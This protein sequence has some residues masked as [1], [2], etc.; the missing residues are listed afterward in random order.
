MSAYN[1]ELTVATLVEL[2]DAVTTSPYVGDGERSMLAELCGRIDHVSTTVFAVLYRKSYAT[3]RPPPSV[4]DVRPSDDA[5]TVVDARLPVEATRKTMALPVL[6]AT[7]QLDSNVPVVTGAT[8]GAIELVSATDVS[9]YDTGLLL[10]DGKPG[11]WCSHCTDTICGEDGCTDRNPCQYCSE[12]R[13]CH[14]LP[15]YVAWPGIRGC[16]PDEVWESY[17]SSGTYVCKIPDCHTRGNCPILAH[18]AEH[19]PITMRKGRD[20][21]WPAPMHYGY[22]ADP[23]TGAL[24]EERDLRW[25]TP[26]TRDVAKREKCMCRRERYDSNGEFVHTYRKCSYYQS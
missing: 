20:A 19:C 13:I 1:K 8:A 5:R 23:R 10:I 25:G 16:A 21:R 11:E 17:P 6:D 7:D 26:A 9:D 24:A 4:T 12:K 18:Y 2:F 3:A 22:I 15:R 14:R